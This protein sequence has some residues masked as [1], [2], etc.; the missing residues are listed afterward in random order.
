LFN[1][2]AKFLVLQFLNIAFTP[3]FSFI[4]DIPFEGGAGS[5]QIPSSNKSLKWFISIAS[6]KNE[7]KAVPQFSSNPETLRCLMYCA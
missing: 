2:A 7:D 1:S 5:A 4:V 6:V 3:S